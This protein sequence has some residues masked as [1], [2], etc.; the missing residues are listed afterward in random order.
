MDQQSVTA[1]SG[2]GLMFVPLSRCEWVEQGRGTRTG[3]PWAES[4]DML[5]EGKRLVNEF[6]AHR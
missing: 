6:M 2:S 3:T 5:V 1:R 4:P